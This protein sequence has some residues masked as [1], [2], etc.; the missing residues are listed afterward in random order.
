[1]Q[2]VTDGNVCEA[3]DLAAYLTPVARCQADVQHAQVDSQVRSQVVL[4]QH[5]GTFQRLHRSG[6]IACGKPMAG[7][8][9]GRLD[10]DGTG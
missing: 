6:G 8:G 4:A 7:F 10:G 9:Q 2:S 5:V 1:M 3:Q